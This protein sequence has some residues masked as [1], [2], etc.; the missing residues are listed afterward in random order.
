MV[1]MWH[2][3]AFK[4]F[5]FFISVNFKSPY[6]SSHWRFSVRK[7][8]LRNFAKFTGKHL[9]QSLYLNKVA[10]LRPLHR[11]FPVNFAKPL[12]TSFSQ[13][14]SG[15]LLLSLMKH[16]TC[17]LSWF[18]QNTK[19]DINSLRAS[20]ASYRNHSIDFTANQL[21]G[22]YMRATLA[23]NRLMIS[24]KRICLSVRWLQRRI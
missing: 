1:K 15:R 7:G 24:V 6:K 4:I 18:I 23:L 22:F 17:N 14:N 19:I 11:C 16:L 2:I 10:D 12:R 5:E 3:K 21:T 9:C 13:N 20:L 8:V